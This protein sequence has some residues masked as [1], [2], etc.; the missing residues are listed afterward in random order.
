MTIFFT[1]NLSILLLSASYLVPASDSLLFCVPATRNQRPSPAKG[2]FKTMIAPGTIPP[3][4]LLP[5]PAIAVNI[6]F[7]AL[8]ASDKVD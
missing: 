6:S 5:A 3:I 4:T 2:G 1:A 7:S 8:N